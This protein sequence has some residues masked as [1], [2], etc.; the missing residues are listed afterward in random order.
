MTAVQVFGV[1]VEVPWPIQPTEN[2][3][4]P[5]EDL[6]HPGRILVGGRLSS[7]PSAITPPTHR[8]SFN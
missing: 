5:S 8:L 3:L 4:T 1:D 6:A 2:G 7:S